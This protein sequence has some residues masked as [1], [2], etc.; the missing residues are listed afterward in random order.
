M[1]LVSIEDGDL[2]SRTVAWNEEVSE[3]FVQSVRLSYSPFSL[4]LATPL[5]RAGAITAVG[6]TTQ[7]W[8]AAWC[9]MEVMESSDISITDCW[10]SRGTSPFGLNV[11]PGRG[12]GAPTVP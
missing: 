10:N 5:E 1:V 2:L 6:G 3:L 12:V 7:S 9:S 4:G 8:G 11:P